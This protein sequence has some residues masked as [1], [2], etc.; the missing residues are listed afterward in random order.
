MQI[1]NLPGARRIGPPA[2]WDQELDGSCGSIFVVDAVD[3][4][5]GLNFMY[6]LYIPTAADLE[7][8][9]NGGA[10]RLGIGGTGHPVFNMV[11]LGPDIVQ[12]CELEPMRDLGPPILEG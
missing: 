4:Q 6:T 2:S 8:L 10:L 11:C 12:Q 7:T 9:N 1:C 3:V 5:S